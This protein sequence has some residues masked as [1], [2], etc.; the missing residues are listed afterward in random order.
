M[1]TARALVRHEV[2]MLGSLVLW[3]ARRSHGTG[4]GRAFGYARGQGAMTFGLAFVCLVETL[5]MSVLL[6]DFPVAHGIVLF[7]D[8]YTMVFVVALHAAQAVRPHVLE[9]GALR[10]RRAVH[11]DLR[12]PLERIASMRRESRTV[13]ERAE[14][15][16]DVAVG[17]QTSLILELAEP[18]DHVTFLGRRR[19]VRLVRFH[20]DDADAVVRAVTR[21][22]NA[23]PPLPGQPA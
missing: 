14:G 9:P 13:H 11:V 4:G 2:R 8:V 3:V 12:I 19:K 18:V 15:E 17:T 10:I 22:R 20:A 1:R 21:A 7:L 16:L 6:R 5:T 23:R